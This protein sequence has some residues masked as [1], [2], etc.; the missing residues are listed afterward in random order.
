MGR[1]GRTFPKSS[2]GAGT[3]AV[4]LEVPARERWLMKSVSIKL[5][6]SIEVGNRLIIFELLGDGL[7]VSATIESPILT[8]ASLTAFG[9]IGQ[10]LPRDSSKQG[11]TYTIPAP[12]YVCE[13]GSILRV[14]DVTDV[15]DVGDV[16][17]ATAHAQVTLLQ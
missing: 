4:D 7:V 14:R 12:E 1:F 16:L 15:D 2:T 8:A 5:V 6:T 17:T 11:Q 10:G 9:N 3:N 13:P